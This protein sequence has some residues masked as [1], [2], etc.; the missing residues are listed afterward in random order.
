MLLSNAERYGNF[1]YKEIGTTSTEL[2][3]SLA[4][5]KAYLKIDSAVEDALITSLIQTAGL[6]FEAMTGV[7]LI[8]KSFLTKRIIWDNYQLR[9]RFIS[10]I[11]LRYYNSE[12]TLTVVLPSEYDIYEE[13]AY[14]I[15]ITNLSKSLSTNKT[16]PI[17]IEFKAGFGDDS[18]FIPANIK[19]A[20][21]QHIASMYENRG[22]CADSN[23]SN[24]LPPLS[25]SIYSQYRGVEIGA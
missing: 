7:I 1:R 9:R 19:I 4:E 2:P 5:V 10:D 23:C 6:C 21:M 11:I 16:Q 25:R 20:L 24:L 13:N 15:L 12:D 8:T 17:E 3:V 18:S 14:D 22:D